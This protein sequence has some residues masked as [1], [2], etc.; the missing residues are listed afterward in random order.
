MN[1]SLKNL[2]NGILHTTQHFYFNLYSHSTYL[3]AR[4]G[5]IMVSVLSLTAVDHWFELWSGHTKDYKI[6]RFCGFSSKH[7]V[8]R[9]K[10]Q[11]I[12][13]ESGLCIRVV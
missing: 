12:A 7:A 1:K 11:M 8:L 4:H 9:S 10:S 5:S 3:N 13:S 2:C 6:Y